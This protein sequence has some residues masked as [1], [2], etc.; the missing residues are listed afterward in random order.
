MLQE[1]H[2]QKAR[3]SVAALFGLPFGEVKRIFVNCDYPQEWDAAKKRNL[4]YAYIDYVSV[5]VFQERKL[6][7]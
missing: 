3:D 4:D 2:N 6:Y 7:G 1:K 5:K